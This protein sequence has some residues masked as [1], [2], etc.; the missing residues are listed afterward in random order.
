[1]SVHILDDYIGWS[2]RGNQLREVFS[3]VLVLLICIYLHQNVFKDF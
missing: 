1:M 2:L 3:A